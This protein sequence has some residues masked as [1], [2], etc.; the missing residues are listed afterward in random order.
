MS[1]ILQRLL[2]TMSKDCCGHSPE[3]TPEPAMLQTFSRDWCGNFP[4][5]APEIAPDKQFAFLRTLRLC[6]TFLAPWSV[7]TP[8]NAPDV[9]F[10]N[11]ISL[12]CRPFEDSF[13]NIW[14][15]IVEKS[16]VY[17]PDVLLTNLMS[18]LQTIWGLWKFTVEKSTIYGTFLH[19]E[20][21]KSSD[22]LQKGHQ[23]C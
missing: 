10:T 20:L 9:L 11:L 23:V 13:S 5:T 17:A 18:F 19:C 1:D 14:K 3:S 6:R 7:W 2:Q 21:S 15:F 8:I 16:Q 12:L 22:G 4:E